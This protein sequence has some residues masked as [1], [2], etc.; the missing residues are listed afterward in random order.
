M[1]A[2]NWQT[3]YLAAAVVAGETVDDALRALGESDRAA[4]STLAA[5][6]SHENRAV[7]AKALASELAKVARALEELELGRA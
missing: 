2:V 6:L 1:I 4:V 5:E 7:R 3:S